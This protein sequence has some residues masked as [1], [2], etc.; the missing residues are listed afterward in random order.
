M[1]RNTRI[2]KTTVA[3]QRKVEAC[4]LQTDEKRQF[5]GK[6]TCSIMTRF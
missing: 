1:E 4:I 3:L 6:Q 5:E 2:V